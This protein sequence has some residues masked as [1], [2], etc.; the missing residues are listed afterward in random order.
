MSVL[1]NYVGKN[2]DLCVLE[3]GSFPGADSVSVGISAPGSVV[4]GP[5][6]VVQKAVKFLLTEKGTVPS[7]PE[8]G[9]KFITKLMSGQIPSTPALKI[10]FGLESPDVK[11]YV[12]AAVQTPTPD[13]D[14]TGMVLESFLVTQD[15]A[16][17]R[18]KFSFLDSSVILAPVQISTV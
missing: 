17:M 8:Y 5:Y 7:D 9:T 10:A 15:S 4:A 18:I 6:K 1:Q 13:E 12:N 3:T 2:V 14:L 11:N 16:V